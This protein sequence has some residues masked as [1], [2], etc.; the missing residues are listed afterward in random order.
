M[1]NQLLFH[2]YNRQQV[3]ECRYFLL[4]YLA[5]YN[6]KPPAGTAVVIYTDQ[7]VAFEGFINF[8]AHFQMPDVLLNASPNAMT[9]VAV[10]QQALLQYSGNLL[11]CDTATYPLQGLEHLFADIEK[12]ALYLHAPQRQKENELNAALRKFTS[13]R[14]KTMAPIPEPPDAHVTVW[15]AAVVGISDREKELIAQLAP[16]APASQNDLALD[17]LFTNVFGEAGK[18]KSAAKYIFDYSALKEFSQL[19]ETF[20]KKN[21]EESIPNQVKLVHHLDAATVQQQKEAYRQQPLFKKWLQVLTGKKWTI[22]Q[23]ES[24]W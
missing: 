7:P 16:E 3:A 18:I 4:K 11:Y 13:R 20:F 8:F 21:E 5:V 23:Y 12:G 22:R 14:D 15:H 17:Y 19:L 10:L 1:P 6:L 24:K 2:A 9:K